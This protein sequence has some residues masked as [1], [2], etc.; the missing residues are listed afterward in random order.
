MQAVFHPVT[1]MKKLK[2]KNGKYR[3]EGRLKGKHKTMH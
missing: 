2:R 1:F 3:S